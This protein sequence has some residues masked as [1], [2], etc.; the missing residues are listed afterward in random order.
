MVNYRRDY[1]KGGV[2]FFTVT[3]KN[4]RAN[5]L[6]Q[7]INIL[8]DAFRF[9][10]NKYAYSTLAITILPDHIHVIWE[11]PQ[12]DSNYS[13]RWRLIKKHVTQELLKQQVPLTKDSRGAYN[14]WQNRFWEHL[15]RNEHDLQKHIDYIHFN[16]VKHGY[17]SIP[18]DW[19][20]S[21]IH[22]YI[23]QGILPCDW[24]VSGERLALY[25]K[26]ETQ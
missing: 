19:P 12:G 24:Y 5:Y 8:G 22:R 10:R 9:V 13:L 16:P 18:A 4:R 3:L 21:S 11:L 25:S 23:K 14:L 6:T 1:T 15:I 7:Y 26:P 2:Y 20:Y 17:T